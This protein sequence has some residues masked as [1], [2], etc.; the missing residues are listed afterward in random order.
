MFSILF[1]QLTTDKIVVFSK[2]LIYNQ[3][4]FEKDFDFRNIAFNLVYS[5]VKAKNSRL[6]ISKQ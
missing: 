6:L 1:C 2:M 3:K 5:V 4:I